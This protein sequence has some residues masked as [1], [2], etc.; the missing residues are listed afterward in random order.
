[1]ARGGARLGAGRKP[2]SLSLVVERS[3]AA[4]IL[5][6]IKDAEAWLECYRQARA[7]GD[8]RAMVDILKYLTDRRDGRPA[9]AINLTQQPG[10]CGS[11]DIARARAVAAEVR[12][13][14]LDEPVAAPPTYT[15]NED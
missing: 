15:E 4:A 11:E 7:D 10:I 5:D 12:E 14:K 3:T 2:H 9:Q 8:V 1:M 13:A 6:K